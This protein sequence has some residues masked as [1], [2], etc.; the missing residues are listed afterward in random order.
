MNTTYTSPNTNKVYTIVTSVS[1]RGNWDDAGNYAPVEF[2]QYSIYDNN[3]MVQFAF[4]E[5]SIARAVRHY[6]MPGP[7]VSSRFD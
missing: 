2:T 5:N 1:E 6:E 3:Q 7:D 4:D